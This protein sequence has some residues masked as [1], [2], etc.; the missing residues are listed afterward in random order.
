MYLFMCYTV[1]HALH[2]GR[3]VDFIKTAF[4]SPTS[5]L[6]WANTTSIPSLPCSINSIYSCLDIPSLWHYK[7]LCLVHNSPSRQPL[8]SQ[9]NPIH[10]FQF[11]SPRLIFVVLSHLLLNIPKLFTPSDIQIKIFTNLSSL[12]FTLILVHCDLNI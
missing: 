6:K 10:S 9:K 12:N 5:N 1:H 8:L 2:H 11:L 7:C 4:R 3:T